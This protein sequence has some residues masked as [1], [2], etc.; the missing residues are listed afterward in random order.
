MSEF[1]LLAH[2]I[3]ALAAVGAGLVNAIAGGGTL[4]SFPVLTALGVPAIGANATNTVSLC[5]GYI[6]G[7]YAQRQDLMGLRVL[8]RP[9]LLAS[10]LGGLVGSILLIVTRESV[11]LQ[12]VPFLILFS[13][14]LL[15]V[16][17]RLR[18][19]LHLHR[20]SDGNGGNTFAEVLAIGT[21]A[22]YG[23][24][25]G[26]GLGIIL[27][28]VLGIFSE[29]PFIRLNAIKQ[30]LSFVISL[31]AAG[32]LLF[33]G[34]V[35]WTLVLVMVPGSIIGGQLGGKLAGSIPPGLLRGF[36]IAFGIVVAM[37]Y[38]FR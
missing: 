6:S 16:Q 33:S 4:I 28:A 15:G 31:S 19:W 38:L 12:I 17:D 11:F 8:L 3:A 35:E 9:Q 7:A 25:F 27:M 29:L 34:K 32:F 20:I 36:V 21:A 14:L 10:A 26:A 1:S 5:P 24:Y 37:V 2:G 30:L 23:G 22:I 13:C 18:T